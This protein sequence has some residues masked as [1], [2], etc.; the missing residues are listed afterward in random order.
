MK[1]FGVP[2]TRDPRPSRTSARIFDEILD[3]YVHVLPSTSTP[4]L[5]L[6]PKETKLPIV[7][8]LREKVELLSLAFLLKTRNLR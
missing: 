6:G 7:I 8:N 2:K 3:F 5:S 1:L 4:T